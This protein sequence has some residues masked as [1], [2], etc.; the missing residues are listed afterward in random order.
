MFSPDPV[1][2]GGETGISD[3]L[4]FFAPF[5]SSVLIAPNY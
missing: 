4:V 3:P 1:Q 2:A 5:F